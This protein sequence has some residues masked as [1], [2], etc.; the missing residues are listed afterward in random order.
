MS[1]NVNNPLLRHAFEAISWQVA[2]LIA[3]QRFDQSCSNIPQN[4][5]DLMVKAAARNELE[6]DI[7]FRLHY[8]A[9]YQGLV[10]YKS[11]LNQLGW[12]VKAKTLST[13]PVPEFH[14]FKPI[15]RGF[16]IQIKSS[17]NDLWKTYSENETADTLLNKI[18]Q[19]RQLLLDIR[20]P[21]S[22]PRNHCFVRYCK[23]LRG[24]IYTTSYVI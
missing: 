2:L 9:L 16:Q 6:E 4:V 19:N 8:A 17:L 1:E 15:N 18:N 7:N 3:L 24:C 11:I 5:S 10:L 23:D 22:I 21:K 12:E 20:W 14:Q 13:E